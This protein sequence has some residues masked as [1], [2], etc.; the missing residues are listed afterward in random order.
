MKAKLISLILIIVYTAT[1]SGCS[2]APVEGEELIESARDSYTALDSARV[3]VVNA[4]TGEVE[5]HFVFKY[6]E[7]DFLTYYY[8]GINGDEVYQQYNNAFEEFTN[9]C[10]E[11]S[12]LHN[13]EKGFNRYIRG[14]RLTYAYADRGLI[15]FQKSA[16]KT[17]TAETSE[18]G[19]TVVTHVYNVDKLSGADGVT[20]FSVVYYFNKDGELE[21]FFENSKMKVDGEIKEFSYEIV[22]YDENAV[23]KV[24]CP[25]ATDADGNVYLVE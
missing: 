13:G 9:N 11:L 25:F 18:D 1:L 10:G 17:A 8:Y 24:D 12:Y 23:D 6:D 15:V 16:V 22:I 3:D 5:Q 20:E 2:S 21:T 14:E 7:R 4:L 19:S